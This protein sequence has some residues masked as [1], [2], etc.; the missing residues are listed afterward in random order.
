MS[1]IVEQHP[2]D[3]EKAM[4]ALFNLEPR[5]LQA[6]AEI[7]DAIVGANQNPGCGGDGSMSVQQWEHLRN[8]RDM[9]QKVPLEI[10]AI[11]RDTNR[12]ICD[13]SWWAE[14]NKRRND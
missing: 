3:L 12:A 5:K 1:D 6:V 4:T 11:V 7:L 14:E 13:D 10:N 9:L 8:L 2:S